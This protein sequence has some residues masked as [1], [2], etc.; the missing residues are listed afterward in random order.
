[1]ARRL[2]LA[3]LAG[4]LARAGAV[5]AAPVVAAWNFD[6]PAAPGIFADSGPRGL[7]LRRGA[8]S[9]VVTGSQGNALRPLIAASGDR[10]AGAE[11]SGPAVDAAT[12]AGDLSP[13]ARRWSL[14]AVLRLNANPT[15]E[16]VLYELA[17][18]PPGVT[19]L[20]FSV[21]VAPAENAFVVRCLGRVMG[22]A[23]DASAV[24]VA[25]PNPG[26]PPHGEAMARTLFLVAAEPLP[27][28]RWFRVELDFA[29]GN[30]LTLRVDGTPVAAAAVNGGLEPMPGEFPARLALGADL[31]GRQP[32]P[33][34]IDEVS[35]RTDPDER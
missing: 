23:A 9:E 21:A 1:M 6:A 25:F 26:G 11:L 34:A 32:F 3:V 5:S 20:V 16:G 2:R 27:R 4:L 10:P 7:N 33:G 19:A 28:G 22:A 24:R 13:G 18:R 29:G 12:A 14:S 17:V 31:A 8:G 30:T 35:I 15:T